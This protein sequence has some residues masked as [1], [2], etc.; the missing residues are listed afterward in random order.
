MSSLQMSSTLS[1]PNAKRKGEKQVKEKEERKGLEKN[2][3]WRNFNKVSLDI[4]RSRQGSKAA[5]MYT[6]HQVTRHVPVP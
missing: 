3:F 6:Y 4:S 5:H 1:P 2:V